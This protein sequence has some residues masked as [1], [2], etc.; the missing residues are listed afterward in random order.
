MAIRNILALGEETL[1]KKSREV[2]VIDGRILTLLEDMAQTLAKA[3]GVGL[4]APQVGILRRVVVIDLGDGLLEM[5]NPVIVETSQEMIEIAEACLSII[6]RRGMVARPA[7][8]K[9]EALNRF[10]EPIIVEGEELLARALCHE[11]DHLDGQLYIDIMSHEIFD[12]EDEE[13]DT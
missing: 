9:V 4:A 1:R 11:I 13:E 2:K 3:E 7:Y 8:V 6:G 10:G 5:I 12:D